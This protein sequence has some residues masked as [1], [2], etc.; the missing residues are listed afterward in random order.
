MPRKQTTSP[1]ASPVKRSTAGLAEAMF[2]EFDALRAGTSNPTR[3]NAAGKI[4][5]TILDTVRVEME[6][7][8]HLKS[9]P[10]DRAGSAVTLGSAL[11]IG[12]K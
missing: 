9:F 3:A 2:E 12:Q 8:K 1:K 4:V 11:Q 7:Q 10:G 5:A 6:V